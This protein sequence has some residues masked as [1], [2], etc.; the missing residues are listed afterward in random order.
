MNISKS[1]LFLALASMNHGVHAADAE[2]A[3]PEPDIFVEQA[4]QTSLTEIEASMVA[5]TKSK[6]PGV[7]SFA[8]RMVRDHG[9]SKSELASLASEIGID[10]PTRLDAEH[11]AMLDDMTAKSGAEFDRSY[12]EHMSTGHHKA[13]ALFEAATNSPDAA[14][15]GFAKKTLP[16]LRE[17]QKLAE[18]LPRAKVKGTS[19][20]GR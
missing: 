19:A 5:L 7:R 9:K 4:V 18:K 6:D 2:S 16:T 17:H 8:Q 14:L 12:S 10:A 20:G 15:S 13:V 1:V 3:I 11:Q